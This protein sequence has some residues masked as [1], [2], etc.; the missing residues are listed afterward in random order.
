M[1]PLMDVEVLVH[2]DEHDL[3]VFT[4]IATDPA[5]NEAGRG[6]GPS[7]EA[8]CGQ[9][10]VALTERATEARAEAARNARP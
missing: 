4:A 10:G 5:G 8:A 6:E 7:I 3:P 2:L 1:T 9:L